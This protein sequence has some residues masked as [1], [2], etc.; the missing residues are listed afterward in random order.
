MVKIDEKDEEILKLLI[1]N[2]RMPFTEIADEVGVSESTI[3]NRIND[4]EEKGVIEKYT[5]DVD[6]SKIGYETVTILGMDVDPEYFLNAV[7]ELNKLD[8][9]KW[10]AQ[11]TGDHMIMAEIWTE[12]GSSLARLMSKKIGKI[13]GVKRLCPAILLNKKVNGKKKIKV[14]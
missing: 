11:S 7:E 6:P 8:E 9:V 3:R 12:N 13:E 4:L 2:S 1:K 10:V 5:I 14:S